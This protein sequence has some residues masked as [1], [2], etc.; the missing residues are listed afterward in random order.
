[1]Q[2]PPAEVPPPGNQV[3]RPQNKPEG[4]KHRETLSLA[5][6]EVERPLLGLLS[7]SVFA[8][9]LKRQDKEL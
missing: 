3:P 1:M 5:P 4:R 6:V 8:L 9:P 7:P 2:P